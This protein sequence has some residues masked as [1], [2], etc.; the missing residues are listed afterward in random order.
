MVYFVGDPGFSGLSVS[1]NGIDYLD[2]THEKISRYALVMANISSLE[3]KLSRRDLS[4]DK[5]KC[6]VFQLK[7][8]ERKAKKIQKDIG[9]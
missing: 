2:K 3:E 6:Y 4:E 7:G 8:L 9:L 1:D 5:R